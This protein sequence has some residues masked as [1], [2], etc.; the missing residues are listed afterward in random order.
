MIPLAPL[1]LHP[2]HIRQTRGFPQFSCACV[3]PAAQVEMAEPPVVLTPEEPANEE[4]VP[5]QEEPEATAPVP[6]VP[7]AEQLETIIP[8]L[9]APTGAPAMPPTDEQAAKRAA[10]LE[11]LAA[12]S[13]YNCWLEYSKRV[14]R[15]LLH[16]HSG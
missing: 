3:V 13:F 12:L 16:P 8:A 11:R 1:P 9:D 5:E 10:L 4:P 14:Q 15:V 2:S 7:T 6:A